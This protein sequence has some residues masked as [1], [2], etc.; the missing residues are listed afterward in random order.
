MGVNKIWSSEDRPIA[1][2]LEEHHAADAFCQRSEP[3]ATGWRL[4]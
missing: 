4:A 2:G 3:K 1:P